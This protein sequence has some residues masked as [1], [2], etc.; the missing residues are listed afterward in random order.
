[1][2]QAYDCVKVIVVRDGSA[3]LL[4]EFGQQPVK[5]GDVILLG[6]NVLCG[7]EPEGHVTATTVYLDT[8]VGT[9]LHVS[10]TFI[11]AVAHVHGVDLDDLPRRRTLLLASLLG[12]RRPRRPGATRGELAVLGSGSAH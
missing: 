10:T 3:I 7:S 11:G 12:G 9:F 2:H 8:N 6:S 4:S 5:S 1:M